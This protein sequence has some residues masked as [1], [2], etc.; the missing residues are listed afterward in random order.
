MEASGT[1][2]RSRESVQISTLCGAV[3]SKLSRE[4]GPDFFFFNLDEV[5]GNKVREVDERSDV[6]FL[7]DGVF[8]GVGRA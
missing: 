8:A 3:V 5:V 1:G 4:N 6:I 7:L 2:M